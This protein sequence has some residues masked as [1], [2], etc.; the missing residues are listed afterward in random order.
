M[1][2]PL[3]L[4]VPGFALVVA[5]DLAGQDGYPARRLVLSVAL[6]FATTALGGLILNALAELTATTWA[7]WLLGFTCICSGIGQLRGS[8]ALVPASGLRVARRSVAQALTAMPWQQPAAVGLALLLFA[9]AAVLTETS[10]RSNYDKPLT[11]LSLVPLAG[12]D[13]QAARVT[14]TNLTPE[15]EELQLTIIRGPRAIVTLP[16]TVLA[17]HSWSREEPLTFSG[18]RAT[19]AAAGGGAPF[20]E[21]S[22]T[23]SG[24]LP[25]LVSRNRLPRLRR[26]YGPAFG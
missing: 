1:V 20:S 12:A 13:G 8:R 26:P 7:I 9:G 4:V 14:I 3:V 19:L 22:W 11:Q 23:G 2:V 25:V 10:S 6:S 15:P 18:L 5:L 21:V 24:A 16:V 17:S